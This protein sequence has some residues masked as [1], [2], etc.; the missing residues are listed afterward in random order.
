MKKPAPKPKQTNTS[1]KETIGEV[2][3][4][5]GIP[6]STTT[7][8]ILLVIF[9][10]IFRNH[11]EQASAPVEQEPA[12]VTNPNVIPLPTPTYR[13]QNSVES[14]I[15]INQPR[16]SF[17]PD[18]FTQKQLSQMLWAAQGVTFDWGG[19]TVT[20]SKST[21]PLTIFVLVNNV[22]KLEKGLYQYIPGERLPAHQLL[23]VKLGDFGPGLFE[24]V[25]QT[26][27]KEPPLVIIVTGDLKKM[28][29]AYGGVAH[30]REVYLEA[31]S[32]IQNMYLQAESLKIGMV[33]LPNFDESQV[34]VLLSIP[35]ADTIIS[36]VPMGYIKE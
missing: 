8:V 30:D 31:G 18:Q 20:S 35:Q 33:S 9:G 1:P 3:G 32:A 15:R 11:Q 36:L 5:W 27:L 28:A 21:F 7:I 26:P 25:N 12:V 13:S 22:E 4:K 29:N 23:P 10:L 14:V 24:I 6:L 19:R 16:R 2:L 17:N 34:R